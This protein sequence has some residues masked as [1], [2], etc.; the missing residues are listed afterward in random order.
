MEF[1]EENAAQSVYL[2][3]IK[4]E[5]Q[6]QILGRDVMVKNMADLQST[7]AH[8]PFQTVMFSADVQVVQT[9]N[10]SYAEVSNLPILSFFIFHFYSFFLFVYIFRS[11]YMTKQ[12]GPIVVWTGILFYF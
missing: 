12:W 3:L 10:S 4:A 1:G 7:W 6:A 11:H 9:G 2:Q 8:V 5:V